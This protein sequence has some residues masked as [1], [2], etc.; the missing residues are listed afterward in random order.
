[1]S[2]LECGQ[3]GGYWTI[4]IFLVVLDGKSALGGAVVDEFD[5]ASQDFN[6]DQFF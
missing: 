5:E 1:M 4:I 6:F 2:I 3:L